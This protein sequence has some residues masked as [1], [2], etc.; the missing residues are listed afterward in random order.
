[1]SF[2]ASCVSIR[3]GVKLG[4]TTDF[5]W[6]IT[7]T[8]VDQMSEAYPSKQRRDHSEVV[9][10]EEDRFRETLEKGLPFLNRAFSE[11]EVPTKPHSPA[12]H[13]NYMTPMASPLI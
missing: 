12:G 7:D 10:G 9:K 11:L 8:V 1:M 2:D 3:Y 4:L 5:L 13:L 6:H